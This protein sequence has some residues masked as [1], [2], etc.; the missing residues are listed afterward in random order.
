MSQA[1]PSIRS[2][3][4]V[5]RAV[6]KAMDREGVSRFPGAEGRIPNF[7]AAKLA[8]QRL[9]GHRL[10]KRARVVKANPDSPQTHVRRIALEEGKVVVMAVPRLRD[11][12]PFR[13][14]DPKKLNKKQLGEAATIKGALRHGRVVADE[15]LPEID[16]WLCGS[17]A[18]NLNGARVG[19]GGGFSDLEYALLVEAGKIDEHTVVGTTVHPIQILREHLMMTAHDLPVDLVATPRAVIDV[20]RAYDRPRGILWDHLQPPQIREVPILERMG[21]A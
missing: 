10:W 11:T 14:L 20:E 4:Q 7:A 3:D 19:K 8:A 18:V 21:Y 16:F 17:V 13:L 6:W 12:H 2:K 15:E 1:A 5:R 9:A